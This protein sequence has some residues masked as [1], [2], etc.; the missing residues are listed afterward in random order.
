MC[1]S[2]LET[3]GDGAHDEDGPWHPAGPD[4]QR[5]KQTERVGGILAAEIQCDAPATVA[6][7][8]AEIAEIDLEDG[9]MPLANAEVRFVPITDG[10]PEGLSAI[11]VAVND[12]EALM[13]AAQSA[14]AVKS[15]RQ[16]ELCGIRINL[17]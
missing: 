10:R 8:W 14:G 15:D 3:L 17:I 9:V 5:A 7:R 2:Y 16:I 1:V 4:W 13:A 11:D 12:R 6:E